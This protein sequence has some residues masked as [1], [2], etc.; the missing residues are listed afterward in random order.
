MIKI[1]DI[2]EDNT[3]KLHKIELGGYFFFDDMLCRRTYTDLDIKIHNATE[4][5]G[6]PVI[7][8]ATGEIIVLNRE[9]WVEPISDRQVFLEISD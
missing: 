3:K 5:D 9:A 2:R 8:V 6:L 7:V 4:E 1:N